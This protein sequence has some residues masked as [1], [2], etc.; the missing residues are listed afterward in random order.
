MV[1]GLW[2]MFKRL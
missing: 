2:T 1:R